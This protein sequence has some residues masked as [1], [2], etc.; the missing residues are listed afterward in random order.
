MNIIEQLKWDIAVCTD[1][2]HSLT[3]VVKNTDETYMEDASEENK[4]F[5]METIDRYKSVIDKTKILLE[6]LFA[7]EKREN[8][9][10]E[11]VYRRL[12]KKIEDAY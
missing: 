4:L 8:I 9:P 11:F 1:E 10:T 2:L 6:A 5:L 7:E 3:K 12:Y